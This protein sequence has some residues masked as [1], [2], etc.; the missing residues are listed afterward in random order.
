MGIELSPKAQRRAKAKRKRGNHMPKA[1]AV[2]IR[3]AD[4]TTRLEPPLTGSVD[5]VKKR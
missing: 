4:G 3:S 2:T 1:S 5:Q